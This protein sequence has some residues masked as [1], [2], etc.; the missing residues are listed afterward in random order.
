MTAKASRTYPVT[1]Q[2]TEAEILD[3]ATEHQDDERRRIELLSIVA[4]H[5]VGDE[6]R[7]V[8][9]P[10]EPVNK[11][12]VV[13]LRVVGFPEYIGPGGEIGATGVLYV[14]DCPG[15]MG[16]GVE[17]IETPNA[18]ELIPYEEES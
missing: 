16:V 11:C 12:E 7:H 5:Q 1:L 13:D 8:D 15:P 3:L 17:T 10:R 2:L 6:V 4:K 18:S 9:S 14:L